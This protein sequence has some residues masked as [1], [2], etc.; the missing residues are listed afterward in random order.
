MKKKYN[1]N[2]LFAAIL[3]LGFGLYGLYAGLANGFNGYIF[4][5]SVV[6]VFL[7]AIYARN[8]KVK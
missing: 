6:F 8:I 3:L 4:V 2:R 1:I 5:P 7:G